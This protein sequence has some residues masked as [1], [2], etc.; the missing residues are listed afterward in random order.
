LR[1]L[2]EGGLEFQLA[3]SDESH[4]ESDMSDYVADE[5]SDEDQSE[6]EEKMS[7]R[8]SVTGSSLSI[9]KNTQNLKKR[10][11]RSYSLQRCISNAQLMKTSPEKVLSISGINMIK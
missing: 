10:E 2:E 6:L 9:F 3:E 1:K 7:N 4:E 11:S 5:E 8:D